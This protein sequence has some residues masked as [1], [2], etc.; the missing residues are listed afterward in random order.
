MNNHSRGLALEGEYD[1][2]DREALATLFG[3]LRADGPATIDLTKV[4]YLDGTMLTELLKLQARFKEH[5]IK[6]LVRSAII[7]RV[8]RIVRFEQLFEIVDA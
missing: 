1:L 7:R 6:L 3:A 4:T 8:F 5:S 2:V